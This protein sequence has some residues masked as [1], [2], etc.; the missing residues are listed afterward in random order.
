MNFKQR[1]F[2]KIKRTS[3]CWE[4]TA[5][6]T[7]GGYGQIRGEDQKMIYAHRAVYELLVGE[8]PEGL[9]IDHLC[10]NRSCVNPDHLEPVTA[11]E[12]I[13][14]GIGIGVG[15]GISNSRRKK[16]HCKNDHLLKS[17]N[18]LKRSGGER[19]CRVCWNEYNKNYQRNNKLLWQ[20]Y[21]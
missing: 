3:D 10:R 4:W 20:Q 16:T 15:V 17:P 13:R 7:Q 2:N 8:I 1:L 6:K 21:Y 14:R 5:Y 11:K 9:Q 12:N 18:L 19:M